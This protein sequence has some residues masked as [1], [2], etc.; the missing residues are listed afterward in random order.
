MTATAAGAGQPRRSGELP[1][2][3]MRVHRI[4]AAG[5]MVAALVG[6]S[7]GSG[8]SSSTTTGV[9]QLSFGTSPTIVDKL[10][11][12][13]VFKTAD[14]KA[15]L[16]GGNHFKLS[17]PRKIDT[18]GG[19]GTKGTECRWDRND[20]DGSRRNL[21]IDVT[22]YSKAASGLLETSWN[23][24]VQSL[25]ITAPVPGMGDKAVSSS[26]KGTTTVAARKGTFVV[27]A[28]SQA[29]GK[30]EPLALN[31]LV[32]LANAALQKVAP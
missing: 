10:G 25:G 14:V 1:S 16:G 19:P 8:K 5:L 24:L 26:G 13:A 32:L 23:G 20:S 27:L 22:D 21:L 7:S 28:T 2:S 15:L 9:P 11:V 3:A 12:C 30:L 6:C 4:L 18:Q 29:T 31:R 17:L